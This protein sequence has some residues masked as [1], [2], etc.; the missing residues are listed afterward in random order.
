MQIISIRKD[1]HESSAA[2][3]IAEAYFHKLKRSQNTNVKIF[4]YSLSN[5]DDVCPKSL[6][7]SRLV[8]LEFRKSGR[9]S[10]GKDPPLSVPSIFEA[11]ITIYFRHNIQ[12]GMVVI[13]IKEKL[14]FAD[15]IFNGHGADFHSFQKQIQMCKTRYKEGFHFQPDY[16]FENVD[17]MVIPARRT[18]WGGLIYHGVQDK[19]KPEIFF[20]NKREMVHAN[21][22]LLRYFT[23][24][25]RCW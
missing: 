7:S 15:W 17:Q 21:T 23:R 10:G 6:L 13:F 1:H 16:K 4:L 20:K 22:T 14:V 9:S 12:P 24:L 5:A 8:T 18:A 2:N 19:H 25:C 11:N 3:R